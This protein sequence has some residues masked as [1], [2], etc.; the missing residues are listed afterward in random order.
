MFFASLTLHLILATAL[1]G[2]LLRT[3]FELWRLT[4]GLKST[5]KNS[6]TGCPFLD[7]ADQS[8]ALAATGTIGSGLWLS[9]VTQANLAA[10]CT[11]LWWYLG[12]TTLVYALVL[13][14]QGRFTNFRFGHWPSFKSPSLMAADWGVVLVLTLLVIS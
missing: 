3:I 14:R 4:Q 11:K 1:G 9:W 13:Y 10:T 7:Q 8:L 2:L 6:L 12:A 5:V